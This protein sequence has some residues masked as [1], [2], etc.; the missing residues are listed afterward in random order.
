MSLI[1]D[2]A[3]VLRRID[4]SETSLVLV[5]LT[6]EHGKVRAVAK[7]AR[8]GTKKRF[9]PGIDLLEVG[10]AVLSTGRGGAAELATLTEWR[11]SYPLPGLRSTMARWHAAQ[12]A[13]EVTSLL[14]EDWDA[15]AGL[16]DSMLEVLH[17]IA[18]TPDPTPVVVEY[19]RRLLLAAG[20]MPV[21]DRCVRCG[22]TTG[23]AH[24]GP[25]A[26]GMLCGR[27]APRA[28]PVRRVT[29]ETLRSLCDEPGAIPAEGALA[30]LNYHIACLVG[31]EPLL[32]RHLLSPS[33]RKATPFRR[34]PHSGRSMR[35][36]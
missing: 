5:L 9:A 10:D 7:G 24:F 26:G 6:R 17:A 31:H 32:G 25:V 19:Q 33:R 14:T 16:F 34:P 28:A 3:V 1:Q 15:H 12:Y 4:Y 30:L 27:C 21:F 8:R 20:S 2:A 29:A 13:A 22:R 18:A 11:Q 36:R 23:L 35:K